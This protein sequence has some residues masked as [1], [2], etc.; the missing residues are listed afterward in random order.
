[1]YKAHDESFEELPLLFF[2]GFLDP[3]IV[4]GDGTCNQ[5]R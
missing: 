2:S 3:Y 1:M 4:W 5:T